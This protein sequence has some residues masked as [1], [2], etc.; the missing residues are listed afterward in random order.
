[1]H[2]LPS[3]KMG[4]EEERKEEESDISLRHRTPQ[5]FAFQYYRVARVD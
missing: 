2:S 4:E 1:M 3:V 5:T